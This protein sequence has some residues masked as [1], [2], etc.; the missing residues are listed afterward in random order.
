MDR[1]EQHWTNRVQQEIEKLTIKQSALEAYIS[2]PEFQVLDLT[3]QTLM[4]TQ[5]DI[6]NAYAN[7]LAARIR[8]GGVIRKELLR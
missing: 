5:L 2:D 1:H 7:I 6:M 4:Y 3:S 8:A